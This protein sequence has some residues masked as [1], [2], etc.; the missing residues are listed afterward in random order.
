MLQLT[1]GGRYIYWYYILRWVRKE[2]FVSFVRC[3]VKEDDEEEMVERLS[4]GIV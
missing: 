1:M 4:L 3:G 2:L